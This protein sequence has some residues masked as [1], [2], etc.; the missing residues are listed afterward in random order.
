MQGLAARY[1]S[2][3]LG[4]LR[5]SRKGAP[6]WFDFGDWQSEMAS[7]RDGDGTITLVTVS[8]GVNGWL[9]FVIA[10]G[11]KQR[12][13]ILRDAQHEYRFSEIE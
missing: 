4:D 2:T 3:E 11:D 10:D 5:V 9:S 13:L 7:R 6:V 1:R 8:P 12:S